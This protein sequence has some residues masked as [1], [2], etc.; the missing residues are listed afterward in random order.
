MHIPVLQVLLSG[1]WN[2]RTLEC[3]WKQTASFSFIKVSFILFYTLLWCWMNYCIYTFANRLEHQ[4]HPCNMY[5]QIVW[6][7]ILIYL[8]H[9]HTHTRVFMHAQIVTNIPTL[10]PTLFFV[11]KMHSYPPSWFLLPRPLVG[12]AVSSN[13]KAAHEQEGVYQADWCLHWSLKEPDHVL[14]HSIVFDQH[15]TWISTRTSD[16]ETFMRQTEIS[17]VLFSKNWLRH[18]FSR[19]FVRVEFWQVNNT[20]TPKK[21]ARFWS[22]PAVQWRSTQ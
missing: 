20:P 10:G 13:P 1:L 22:Q 4:S 18:H 5:N 8:L 11:A 19:Y 17:S 16:P 21:R 6:C 9:R 12:T 3:S 14:G 2:G 7:K 15:Q